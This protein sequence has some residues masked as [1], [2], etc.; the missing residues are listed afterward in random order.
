MTES[1]D[2]P[3]PLFWE[4]NF[5]ENF[6]NIHASLN[7]GTII[8][9]KDANIIK[10]QIRKAIQ[11]K[12][13]VV[14]SEILPDDL[15][16]NLLDE[17]YD[18]FCEKY[19]YVPPH[20]EEIAIGKSTGGSVLVVL[21]KTN[22][23]KQDSFW[24]TFLPTIEKLKNTKF[25]YADNDPIIHKEISKSLRDFDK[26]YIDCDN[27]QISLFYVLHSLS[28][29]I[30]ILI[31]NHE[32][33]STKLW[34]LGVTGFEIIKP[35]SKNTSLRSRYRDIYD[36]RF[37]TPLNPSI[38]RTF[39]LDFSEINN[40]EEFSKNSQIKEFLYLTRN[41]TRNP[42]NVTSFSIPRN[43]EAKRS[44]I[45]I[46]R[47]EVNFLCNVL[48]N[49]DIDQNVQKK[50][51]QKLFFHLL[52]KEHSKYTF[53]KLYH[54][55]KK[56]ISC[57]VF[58]VEFL[59]LNK[60]FMSENKGKSDENFFFTAKVLYFLSLDK[61][62]TNEESEQYLNNCI[63]ILKLH[64][65]SNPNET[66]VTEEFLDF[67]LLDESGQLAFTKDKVGLILN[68]ELDLQKTQKLLPIISNKYFDSIENEAEISVD[69]SLHNGIVF[70]LSYRAGV[71]ETEILFKT[72]EKLQQFDAVT[73]ELNKCLELGFQSFALL[74]ILREQ[75]TWNQIEE[76]SAGFT[77]LQK[78]FLHL[79]CLDSLD[80]RELF[81]KLLETNTHDLTKLELSVH[82]SILVTLAKSLNE[83]LDQ[84]FHTQI[85]SHINSLSSTEDVFAFA[86]AYFLA[87]SVNHQSIEEILL[88]SESQNIIFHRVNTFLESQ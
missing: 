62:N 65:Q 46:S 55:L 51:F 66:S 21:N 61:R 70:A 2:K 59:N 69:E 44:N 72:T 30:P 10:S 52:R 16:D 81:G 80:H 24:K 50:V 74:I 79:H 84:E 67:L 19:L 78:N 68:K 60:T 32:I 86:F 8:W 64:S 3:K 27:P 7:V 29:K 4:K 71:C 58:L 87:K 54:L 76:R 18:F 53:E 36:L 6:C 40:F 17:E 48:K 31:E 35:D 85:T 25:V 56:N 43:N 14:L 5:I 47:F 83:R 23:T 73:E 33:I 9:N 75:L 45:E 42:E 28:S 11:D 82:Y 77:R 41:N 38:F 26:I 34:A 13:D 37:I 15:Q 57:L 39:N 1:T 22:G 63:S 49:K 88:K 12:A 20:I